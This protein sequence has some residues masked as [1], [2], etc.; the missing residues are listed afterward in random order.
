MTGKIIIHIDRDFK[1]LIPEFMSNR[2]ND[3]ESI[4]SALRS[5]DF[6]TIRILGHSMKGFAPAYGFDVLGDIGK[7]LED[8]AKAEDAEKIQSLTEEL[9]SYIK[10]VE[11]VFD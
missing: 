7:S 4:T 5:K 3:I 9:E 8:A 11:V 1:D 2:E 10:R 6:E